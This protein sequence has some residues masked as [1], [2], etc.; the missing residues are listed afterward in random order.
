MASDEIVVGTSEGLTAENIDLFQGL[1]WSD[2][3][4]AIA[5]EDI[6]G[7]IDVLILGKGVNSGK[8]QRIVGGTTM[9]FGD[10]EELFT[11]DIQG[12]NPDDLTDSLSIFAEAFA[13]P[14]PPESIVGIVLRIP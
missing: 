10:T 14:E 6:V 12:K 3:L 4:D 8:S 7:P 9:H 2:L 13:L 11:M 1:T 5:E